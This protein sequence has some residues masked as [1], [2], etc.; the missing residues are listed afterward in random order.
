MNEHDE[1][2]MAKY[3]ITTET[4]VLFY[5]EGYRYE[6]LADAVNYARLQQPPSKG[7]NASIVPGHEN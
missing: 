6:R 7:D 3:G 5:Y 2:L 4:K 1:S